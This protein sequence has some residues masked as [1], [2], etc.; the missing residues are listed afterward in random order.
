MP[1]PEEISL[2][3]RIKNSDKVAFKEIYLSFYNA[4][5]YFISQYINNYEVSK[6]LAQEAF[7]LLWKNRERIN[8]ELGYKSYLLSIAKNLTLNFLRNQKNVSKFNETLKTKSYNDDY[9]FNK[10][11]NTDI[12]RRVF[13]EIENLPKK[14]KEVIILSRNNNLTNKQISIKLGISIKTVEYRLMVALRNI[15]EN[16]K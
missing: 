13:K 10:I 1:S 8:H 7:F 4:V 11:E 2:A 15:R 3:Y 16:I 14:Q 9:L 12:L 6:D 5:T